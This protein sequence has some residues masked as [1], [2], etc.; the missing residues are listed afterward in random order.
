M[1]SDSPARSG[2]HPCASSWRRATKASS[3]SSRRRR[4]SE[5]QDHDTASFTCLPHASRRLTTTSLDGA[6][7]SS[8]WRRAVGRSE[9]PVGRPLARE[10]E[11]AD[12]RRT[13]VGHRPVLRPHLQPLRDARAGSANVRA[14]NVNTIDEVPDSSWF[15][16][17]IGSRAVTIDEAVRGPIVGR[18]LCRR[19]GSSRARRARAPRQASRRRTPTGTRGSCRSTRPQPEGRRGPGRRHQ[20]LLALGY[21]QVEYFSRTCARK[22]SRF[23]RLQPHAG[24]QQALTTDRERR[25]RDPGACRPASD[26]S[27]RTARR[28]LPA[29]CWRL[30]VPGHAARRSQRPRPARAQARTPGAARLRRMDEPH[31]HEGGNT[32]THHHRGRPR[33]HPALRPGRRIDVW[34]GANGPHDW[35]EVEYLYDGRLAA[36]VLTFGFGFSPWQTATTRTTGRWPLRRDA[37]DPRPGSPASDG[38]LLR[39]ARRRRVL[40]RRRVMR[41]PRPDPG[42]REDGQYS[43]PRPSSTWPMC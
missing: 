18:R 12:A 24:R 21:N 26:G 39:N 1:A 37:F 28:M 20:D 10:P 15:T 4:H 33:P 11:T 23:R 27:Y 41:S 38:G 30:Q 34:V 40:G 35:N 19:N 17:R 3:S 29:R 16:N 31:G 32:L 2:G 14:Q 42:H 36:P 7:S 5:E 9:V 25:A 22:R 6:C 8:R 43:D 13:A